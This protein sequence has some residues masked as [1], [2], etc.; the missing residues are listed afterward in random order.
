MFGFY[1]TKQCPKC[2]FITVAQH[3]F[4]PNCGTKLPVDTPP[5]QIECP[6]CHGTGVR[7]KYYLG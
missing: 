6:M 4:C 5:T 2:G 1:G 3:A 7:S